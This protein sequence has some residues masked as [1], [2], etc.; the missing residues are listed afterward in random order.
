MTSPQYIALLLVAVFAHGAVGAQARHVETT[1]TATPN[2][3]ATVEGRVL[4]NVQGCTH[5]LAC[6]LRLDW[7][8]QE[9]R[10]Y[11]HRGEFSPCTDLDMVKRGSSVARGD[12]VRAY[13]LYRRVHDLHMIDVCTAPA[14]AMLEIRPA[15]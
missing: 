11:Y 2:G 14:G 7:R 1:L 15:G 3:F 4:L 5:D 13:G 8:G 10:I 6:Y 12:R 9:V